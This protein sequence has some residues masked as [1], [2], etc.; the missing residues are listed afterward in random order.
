MAYGDA[1]PGP[2]ATDEIAVPVRIGTRDVHMGTRGGGF[3]FSVLGLWLR[4]VPQRWGRLTAVITSLLLALFLWCGVAHAQSTQYTY[5]AD[6]RVVGIAQTSKASTQYTYNTLG[7]LAQVNALPIGQ[8]AIFAFTPTQGTTGAQVTI[9]GQGFSTTAASNSVA[10]NGVAATVLSAT[11]A[12]LVVSVPSGA[13][14]GLI[15]V[16]VAGNTALSAT[17][18]II[19]NTGLPPTIT[20]FSPTI[21]NSGAPVTVTGAQLDPV[22]GGTSVAVGS[23]AISPSTVAD[24]QIQFAATSSGYINVQTPFGTATSTQPLIV[25]PSTIATSNVASSGYETPNSSPVTLSIG[26]TGQV[27]VLMVQANAGGWVSIQA[28]GISPTTSSIRYTAYAPNGSQILQGSVSASSPSIHLPQISIGGTYTVVFQSNTASTQITLASSLDTF[29]SLSTPLTT[30]TTVAYQSQR[31]L[32][33]AEAGQ[34]LALSMTNL[35]TSPLGI[36]LNYT[37]FAPDGSQYTQSGWA[38]GGSGVNLSNVSLSGVYQIVFTPTAAASFT[39]QIELLPAILGSQATNGTT[40]SYASTGYGQNISFSFVASQGQNLELTLTNISMSGAASN[41]FYVNVYSASGTNVTGHYCYPSSVGNCTFSLWN[42][43]A[44]VYTVV[45]ES[46]FGGTMSF[47]ALIK[48]DVVGSSLVAGTPATVN[49]AVG[50]VERLTFSGTAG[51]N[52][53][54]GITNLSTTPAGQ[55][56]YISVYRPDVGTITTSNYWQQTNSGSSPTVLN[57]PDLPVSGT[58][59]VVVS[60]SSAVP[61]TVQLTLASSTTGAQTA[62]GN[63]TSYASAVDGQNAYFTFTAT[64]GQNLELTLDDMTASGGYAE[65]T[66]TSATGV[67]VGGGYCGASFGCSFSLWNLPAGTYSVLVN[68]APS[69]TLQ[70]NAIVAPDIVGPALSAGVPTTVNLSAGQVERLTFQGAQGGT[71]ALGLSGISTTP[72]GQAVLISVY[73]PDIALINTSDHYATW[74]SS[75]GPTLN[76]N[77]LPATGTYTVVVST[78]YGIPATVQLTLANGAAGTVPTNGTSESYASIVPEQNA[79]LSFSATQG[80]NLELSFNDITNVAGGGTDGFTVNVDNAKGTYINGA[81][82]SSS[83]PGSSCIIPLWN[84]PTGNYSVL[85]QNS[86]N[87][88]QFNASLQPDVVGPVLPVGSAES[89]NIGQGQAER[90]SFNANLGDT[91]VLQT[92][93]LTSVPTGQSLCINVYRPD[94]GLI[95]TN[96]TFSQTCT[97]T[98]NSTGATITIPNLPVGGTYTIVAATQYGDPETGSIEL[99]S[100]TAGSPP[101]YGTTTLPSTGAPQGEESSASGQ[102]ITMTFNATQGQNLELALNNVVVTGATANQFTINVTNA[103][104]QSVSSTWCYQSNPDASCSVSLW[105]LPA[106]T[107][108]VVATPN[109]G[110]VLQFNAMLQPDIVGPSLTA[111]T[112]TNVTL[113][114]GQV[115]RL[116]FNGTLGATMA[117]GLSGVTTTPGG[118]DVYV[119][120]YSPNG[121]LISPSNYYVQHDIA[122]GEYTFNLTNLPATGT[123][124]VVVS[125]SYELPATAQLLL[126]NGATGTQSTNDTTQSYAANETNQNVYVSFNA[127]QGQNL[128]LLISGINV[129]SYVYVYTSSGTEILT[130]SCS[131][132][133]STPSC[134]FPLWD[135]P[136][137]T[138]SVILTPISGGQ[139]QFNAAIQPDVVGPSLVAGTPS[140]VNLQAGQVERFTFSGTLGQTVALTLSKTATVPAGQYLYAYVYR[141]DT[142]PIALSNSYNSMYTTGTATLNLAD[143]PVTGTYTVVVLS[144]NYGLPTT[145]QLTL[146]DG[147]TGTVA[148]TGSEQG[149][150]TTEVGQNVYF[151]FTAKQGQNLELSMLNVSNFANVSV[152][153]PQGAVVVQYDCPYGGPA[154][155]IQPL[156]N[157]QAGTYSV[158]VEPFDNT[159]LQFSALIQPDVVGPAITTSS[160]ATLSLSAGQAERVTFQGTLHGAVALQLSNLVTTPSGQT[161]Y[162]NVYA[163]NGGLITPSGYYQQMNSAGSSYLNLPNLPATGTYTAVVYSIYGDPFTAQLSE[164]ASDGGSLNGSLGQFTA[165]GS[166]QTV[167]LNFTASAGQN[168][169]LTL[170]NINVVGGSSDEF[171]VVVTAPSGA[172]VADFLCNAST[173]GNSCSQSLWD[174]SSG[175]YSV[176]ATPIAGGTISF[177]ALVLP[178]TSGTALTSGSSDNISLSAGQVERIQFA[179]TAGESATL[180]LTDVATTPANQNLYVYIYS[181]NVGVIET[182]NAYATFQATTSGSVTLPNLPVTG[183]YTAVITTSSGLPATAQLSYTS[184]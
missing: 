58:Y 179:G 21:V 134:L 20:Q 117:L 128:D 27:G 149:F 170:N 92:A 140:S 133:S 11:A 41:L 157:L 60:T 156:W 59:A 147:V 25:L 45:A 54:L 176:V 72:S 31:V 124:T 53:A 49:L 109:Y 144:L 99:L 164:V 12:Q 100:D 79:Y 70:F 97:N 122:S 62:N 78:Y 71:A 95:Q 182:Y 81:S 126:A 138:Y 136:A 108:T 66:V 183:T 155:C 30:S 55:S 102:P 83:S 14:T 39:A 153:G 3:R 96:N 161:V 111:G 87:L 34:N 84:L 93:G 69:S 175:G 98:S 1:L 174:L 104:N 65:V 17:P 180:Q 36:Q 19:G 151:S 116:T 142:G 160:P 10:F 165:P 139:V 47:Q 110:G 50:Q 106:G 113:A 173:P 48:P 143:L 159:T 115:E 137:G 168:L 63:P 178:D 32:F 82:C 135:L 105:N 2:D 16:T 85:I 75:N 74:N 172:T 44:G 158:V 101:T 88:M 26:T 132:S 46:I 38:S 86:G 130:S 103:A 127:T 169:E 6:G 24:T 37:I 120:I 90:F 162:V 68:P 118:Q 141:P 28:T 121:G 80:Q 150:A 181:P 57:L 18:F 146:T 67:Y 51:S 119:S 35:V 43:P 167:N 154:N 129:A 8:V 107:Y 29:L 42:L 112:P 91:V 33:N 131:P 76:L 52:V 94:V 125:S 4:D 9:E 40:Q 145:A 77:N 56:V 166:G 89:I 73:R 5:D 114:A 171:E 22:T 152:Y 184:Q 15:S 7:H 163:P 177:D 61:A 23:T 123:Y 13:S 148:T 64:E